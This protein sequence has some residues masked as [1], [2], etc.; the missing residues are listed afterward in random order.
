MK[1]FY[2]GTFTINFLIRTLS[3]NSKAVKYRHKFFALAAIIFCL[4][5][6]FFPLNS[7]SQK[8]ELSYSYFNLTRN[9]GGG[10]L[11]NGDIIEIHALAKV[12]ATVQNIYYVDTIPTG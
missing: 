1:K 9:T 5:Q 8:L 2:S 12:N 7:F 6:A 10:T 4:F 3:L 11:E